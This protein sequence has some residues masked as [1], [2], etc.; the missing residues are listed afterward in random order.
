MRINQNSG[1]AVI[2]HGGVQSGQVLE[3]AAIEGAQIACEA[4]WQ[5]LISSG[6]GLKAVVAGLSELEDNELFDAGYGSFPNDRGEIFT[7]IGLMAGTGSFYSILNLARV[8]FPSRVAID[9]F[10]ASRS[11]MKVW[12][13]EDAAQLDTASLELKARYGWVRTHGELISPRARAISNSARGQDI[14]GTVGCLVRDAGGHLFAGTSTGGIAAKPVAR[15]GDSPII[16]AGVYARDSITALS[17]TGHGES[18]LSSLLSG[19]VIS[20]IRQ[21]QN[22][23]QEKIT[24]ASI[25]VEEELQY[26]KAAYPSKRAGLILI[27]SAEPPL[28]ASVGGA[29]PVAWKTPVSSGTA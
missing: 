27:P 7:D 18:I 21:S 9:G 14:H 4:A 2:V 22:P 16:G 15:I 24:S 25:I 28:Y 5:E 19:H 3:A 20:R 26:F 13:E 6:D 29:M 10:D 23:S 8:R 17:A 11:L 12:T 1:L